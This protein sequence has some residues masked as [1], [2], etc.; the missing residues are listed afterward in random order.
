MINITK[1]KSMALN[2]QLE[3]LFFST[4]SNYSFNTNLKTITDIDSCIKITLGPTGK[5]GIVADKR[6]NLTFINR[7]TWSWKICNCRRL[8][9][10]NNSEKS[11]SNFIR[12]TC[13][14][15]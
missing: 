5:N 13:G 4:E 9:V 8:S 11:I 12:K 15:S 10:T 1:L 14:Y 7:R 2:A 6:G 3:D